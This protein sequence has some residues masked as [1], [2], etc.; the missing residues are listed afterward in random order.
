[1]RMENKP[2]HYVYHIAER[3]QD[4]SD[5]KRAFWTKIGAAWPHSD[6][7]GFALE[8]VHGRL[9]LREPRDVEQEQ[10]PAEATEEKEPAPVTA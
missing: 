7:K 10:A 6:G 1:M 4:G 9:V 2:T 3:E 5:E 8:T